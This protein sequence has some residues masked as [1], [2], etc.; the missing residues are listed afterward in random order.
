[1][2]A[3]SVFRSCSVA[4]FTMSRASS[5]GCAASFVTP[6]SFSC[7]Q[8][9]SRGDNAPTASS[10]SWTTHASSCCARSRPRSPTLEL[11]SQSSRRLE[12][13]R[14]VERA[15]EP[16]GSA[17][18]RASQCSCRDVWL[19]PPC[20]WASTLGTL[21]VSSPTPTIIAGWARCAKFFLRESR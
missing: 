3:R 12:M 4:L 18:C 6:P 21:L 17:L 1:M 13:S 9:A 10:S 16:A 19:P 2:T 8:S 14:P 11:C 5:C 20:P 7:P 15:S